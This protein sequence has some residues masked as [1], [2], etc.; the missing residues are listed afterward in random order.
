[1]CFV[2][3]LVFNCLLLVA[4]VVL[5]CASL[6]GQAVNLIRGLVL[7]TGDILFSGSAALLCL[8]G[9]ISFRTGKT[10]KCRKVS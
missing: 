7:Q 5:A 6:T 4:C 10:L 3:E 9:I 2:G 8:T 1:M